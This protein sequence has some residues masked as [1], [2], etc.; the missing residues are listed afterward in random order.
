[1]FLLASALFMTTAQ[2]NQTAQVTQDATSSTL[3]T[4]VMR[5]HLASLPPAPLK[6]E[7]PESEKTFFERA[8]RMDEPTFRPAP[9]CDYDATITSYEMMAPW[10]S[11]INQSVLQAKVYKDLELFLGSNKKDISLLHSIDRTYLTHG[12]I[13]L[14][15]LLSTPT[16]DIQT[17]ENRQAIIRTVVSTP[18]LYTKLNTL[19]AE[20]AKNEPAIMGWF[21]AEQPAN[22][23][24]VDGQYFTSKFSFINPLPLNTNLA[25]QHATTTY[26]SLMG[27]AIALLIAP[28][29][30]HYF[31]YKNIVGPEVIS[32]FKVGRGIAITALA[33]GMS[34]LSITDGIP[35][36]IKIFKYLHEKSIAIAKVITAIDSITKEIEKHPEFNHLQYKKV[37]VEFSKTKKSLSPKMQKL[38]SLLRTNTFK[39]EPTIYALQGRVK[40]AH[41]LINEIKHELVPAL[42]ALA[43]LDAY[44][45]CANIYKEYEVK[46]NRFAFATYAKQDTPYINVVNMWNPFV[47]A[48]K[49]VANSIELG[50]KNPRNIILTGPNAG[51]K[52]TFSKGVAIEIILAQTIGI[53]PAESLSLTPFAK[54]NTYMNIADDTAGGNSLFKSEVMRAQELLTTITNLPKNQFS[55]SAMDE[56]FSGTSPREGEAAGYAVAKNIG[57]H[58]NS[59]AIIATHFPLLKELEEV[60]PDFKN[61]QVRVIR[62]EDGT[63]SYPFKLERGA[64]DQNVA[65][66]ILK[67]QNFESSILND[68]HAILNRRTKSQA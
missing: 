58:S 27:P 33:A 46:N 30:A 62:H 5:Q 17:L 2:C 32:S 13:F 28:A 18:E 35:K 10:L 66:D 57:T 43:E 49:S 22:K 38:V 39:G 31:V 6:K 36:Q 11:D 15:S 3:F 51:G 19:Y 9:L 68:A 8:T 40:V 53:V 24:Y 47:G 29:T 20:L 1:M 34:Y 14:A 60:T 16:T 4:E 12:Q 26:A 59:I 54:I 65:I 61:Y 55:F 37:F 42:V 25:Y 67:N 56:M 45:S 48:E 52:S 41:A 50:G 64:A 63:F 44:L 7:K 23:L 21:R